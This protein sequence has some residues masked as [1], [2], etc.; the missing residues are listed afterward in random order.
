[1]F[2]A[3]NKKPSTYV[4]HPDAE[5]LARLSK[6]ALLDLLTEALRANAGHCDTP[7][8]R[9]EIAEFCNATLRHRGDREI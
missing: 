8:T 6:A 3:G 9:E 2:C 1:M 4:G 5:I 7:C